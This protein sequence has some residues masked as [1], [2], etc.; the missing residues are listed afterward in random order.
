[1]E[2]QYVWMSD[3]LTY[4]RGLERASFGRLQNLEWRSEICDLCRVIQVLGRRFAPLAVFTLWTNI[5]TSSLHSTS[6][7]LMLAS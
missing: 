7:P 5:D 1:M 6:S 2:R 4:E 3:A